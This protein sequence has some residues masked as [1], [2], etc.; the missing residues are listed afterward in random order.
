MSETINF[1]EAMKRLSLIANELEMDD[2]PLD[3]AIQL[4][5]EGL[6]L[7]ALCQKQLKG[8]EEKVQS[9]VAKHSGEKQ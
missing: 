2:L 3:K 6:N 1:E 4:F 8:Y 9:L 7:S 5:E